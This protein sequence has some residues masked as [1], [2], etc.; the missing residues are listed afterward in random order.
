MTDIVDFDKIITNIGTL[1]AGITPDG[2]I[3]LQATLDPV[4]DIAGLLK[5]DPAGTSWEAAV[6]RA[7]QSFLASKAAVAAV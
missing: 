1:H 3:V 5:I 6:L 4:A 7:L 2:K